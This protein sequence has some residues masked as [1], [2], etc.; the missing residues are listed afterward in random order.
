[1]LALVIVLAITNAV[2]AAALAYLRF[3][4]AAPAEPGDEA[5]RAALESLAQ[6]SPGTR[7]ER[8]F[9]S[10]EILNPIELAATR[11]RV[12][13]LAGTFAPSFTRRLVYDQTVR[14]LRRQL[15]EHQVVADV[16]VHALRRAQ[17]SGETSRATDA[18][19]LVIDAGDYV[20]DLDREPDDQPPV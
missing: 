6:Q 1:L 13:G 7:R 12:L 18:R 8:Q 3:R 20:D 17:A 15:A 9:I 5:V 4:P 19:T 2:T 14:T 10:V 11:G 16:H